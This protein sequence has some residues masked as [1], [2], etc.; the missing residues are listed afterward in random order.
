MGADLPTKK[1]LKRVEYKFFFAEIMDCRAN[2]F[3]I[4]G[5]AALNAPMLI[6]APLLEHR[7]V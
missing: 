2:L 5:C 3:E 6:M 4:C 1:L 7:H